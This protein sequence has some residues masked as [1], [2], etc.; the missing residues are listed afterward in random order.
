MSHSRTLRVTGRTALAVCLLAAGAVLLAGCTRDVSSTTSEGVT[1]VASATAPASPPEASPAAAA[2]PT[3]TPCAPAKQHD[4]GSSDIRTD[5]G[6][7]YVLYVPPSYDGTTA[8]PVVINLHGDGSN[9]VQQAFVSGFQFKA[10]AADFITITPDATGTPQ[11]WNFLPITGGA[12]DI[13]FIRAALDRTEADLCVD[14]SRVYATGISSGASMAVRLACSLPD[15]IAAIGL[16]AGIWYPSDCPTTKPMPVI[17]FHGTND[18]V[19]PFAGGVVLA[20]ATPSPDIEDAAAAWANADGCDPD[21][22]SDRVAANVRTLA[23]SQ[24]RDNV[25]V[26]LFIVEGGGHTW[27]GSAAEDLPATGT[28]THEV[29]ATDEIWQFFVGQAQE[30][31]G[32]ASPTAA[33]GGSLTPVAGA[34]PTA[35]AAGSPITG[36]TP[37]PSPAAAASPSPA[38]SAS[39]TATR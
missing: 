34:S 22:A 33:A 7:H 23:Y 4:S 9:A 3:A 38:S 31:A 12:D 25:A 19:A 37:S 18:P 11:T 28:T 10:A 35:A 29:N 15:R 21:A 36:A 24:C 32:D 8:L 1:F 14:A 17:E 5:D 16:V 39:S 13:G 27:P 20:G 2:I 6:R 26:E 30:R